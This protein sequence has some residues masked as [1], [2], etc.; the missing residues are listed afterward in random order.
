LEALVAHVDPRN[1]KKILK[2]ELHNF[3][4]TFIY[5]IKVQNNLHYEEAN[6]ITFKRYEDFVEIIKSHLHVRL[7]SSRCSKDLSLIKHRIVNDAQL[8]F[9]TGLTFLR[10][11]PTQTPLRHTDE[12][13]ILSP[14]LFATK[15]SCNAV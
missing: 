9:E 10:A 7:L 8:S 6:K 4:V 2:L 13:L 3:K 12:T 15:R 14:T 11:F 1:C 5:Y